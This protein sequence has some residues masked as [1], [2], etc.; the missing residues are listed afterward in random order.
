MSEK[1]RWDDWE[2]GESRNK[3]G[4]FDGSYDFL[5]PEEAKQDNKKS[6]A[7]KRR[8]EAEGNYQKRIAPIRVPSENHCPYLGIV[9]DVGKRLPYCMLN[10]AIDAR[11][12]PPRLSIEKLVSHCTE[13]M[14]VESCEDYIPP[15]SNK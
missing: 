12:F 10:E 7:D 4:K 5:N 11:G 13:K 6:D 15:P 3:D 2:S 1:G 8:E 9:G 14:R